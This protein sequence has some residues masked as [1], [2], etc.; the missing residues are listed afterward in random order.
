MAVVGTS[1]VATLLGVGC[2]RVRPIGSGRCRVLLLHAPLSSRLTPGKNTL[3]HQRCLST[4]W[5]G[6]NGV[7]PN[8]SQHTVGAEEAD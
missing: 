4:S 3:L 1:G 8:P 6:G 2:G 7:A 5:R